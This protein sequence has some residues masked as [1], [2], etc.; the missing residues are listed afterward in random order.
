MGRSLAGGVMK[1][2]VIVHY[3]NGAL[4]LRC[5]QS[6]RSQVDIVIVVDNSHDLAGPDWVMRLPGG[7]NLGYA[8]GCNRGLEMALALG[9][10]TVVLSNADAVWTAGAVDRMREVAHLRNAVVAPMLIDQSGQVHS[11]G[12]RISWWR[13]NN[14]EYTRAQREDPYSVGFVCAAAV[15]LPTAILS[16]LGPMCEEYFMYYDDVDWCCRA[17]KC[18]VA[19]ILCPS[20]VV[21][22]TPGASGGS[23]VYAEYGLRNRLTWASKWAPP[24]LRPWVAVVGGLLRVRRALRRR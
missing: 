24:W 8:S 17:H 20:A 16:R 12:G 6:L 19:M 10:T 21:I 2:A 14:V 9:A 23:L 22:H 11:A 3:K 15:V 4:T 7:G 5:A 18:G 1:V 13:V